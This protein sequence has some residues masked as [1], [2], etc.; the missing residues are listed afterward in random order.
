MEACDAIAAGSRKATSP[1]VGW[2]GM[3]GPGSTEARRQD[4]TA[5]VHAHDR[6][7]RMLAYRL[8]GDREQMDEALRDAFVR[9]YR[10]MPSFRNDAAATTWLYRITYEACLDRL[11]STSRLSRRLGRVEA[12]ETLADRGFEPAG[13][14]D[15]GEDVAPRDDLE[16][17]LGALPFERRAALVLVDVN[18]LDHAT[19]ADILGVRPGTLTAR[20]RAARSA[21]HGSLGSTGGG[22]GA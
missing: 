18:G 1:W 14:G 9:A 2:D 10:A 5:L 11:R 15:S 12:L 4:F 3:H 22:A 16:D 6:G 21:L 7:L 8:L 13:P 19:T 17:A 20:L